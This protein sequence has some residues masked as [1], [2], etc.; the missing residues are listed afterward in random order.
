MVVDLI[1]AKRE[2]D[3]PEIPRYSNHLVLNNLVQPEL[4]LACH[5]KEILAVAVEI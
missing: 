5:L 2:S 4:L 3:I 1:L